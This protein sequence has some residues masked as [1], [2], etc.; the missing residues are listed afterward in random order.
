MD[1]KIKE[2]NA[3]TKLLKRRALQ[4]CYLIT[5]KVSEALAAADAC[6]TSDCPSHELL[7]F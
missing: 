7:G 2:T 4:C 1:I 5:C 3:Y 6:W